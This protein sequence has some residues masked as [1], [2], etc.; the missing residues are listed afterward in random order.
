M[1]RNDLIQVRRDTAANWTANNPTLATGEIG[2]E[3]NTGKL[4]VG[5]ASTAWNSLPYVT[6]ASDV[7][8]VF[9]SGIFSGSSS[10]DLVR[11][12]QTGSGNALVVEDSANHD[13]TPFVVDS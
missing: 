3:T 2:F 5:T 12:T 7:S 1:A 10:T 6:D 9:S 11:I 8:G 4:K 13:G